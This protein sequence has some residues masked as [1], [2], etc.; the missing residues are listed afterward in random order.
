MVRKRLPSLLPCKSVS[1]LSRSSMAI[2]LATSKV[3]ALDG[4]KICQF[5]VNEKGLVQ[6]YPIGEELNPRNGIDP[7]TFLSNGTN[8]TEKIGDKV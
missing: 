3:P 5:P 7:A 2:L 8:P 6:L 4:G 1:V